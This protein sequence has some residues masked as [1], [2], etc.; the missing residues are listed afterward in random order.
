MALQS[1]QASQFCNRHGDPRWELDTSA[2][3]GR[4]GSINGSKASFGART[5]LALMALAVSFVFIG[6]GGSSGGAATTTT[7]DPQAVQRYVD[8]VRD[9]VN[10]TEER[11]AVAVDGP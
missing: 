11:I 1:S 9:A 2:I 8:S 4:N 7:A 6:C 10:Q 3:G 5:A